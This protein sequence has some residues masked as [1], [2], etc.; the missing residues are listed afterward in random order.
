MHPYISR[1][2]ATILSYIP[3]SYLH[4][5]L[6]TALPDSTQDFAPLGN[7]CEFLNALHIRSTAATRSRSAPPPKLMG[8]ITRPGAVG[9]G[10]GVESEES[11]VCGRSGEEEVVEEGGAGGGD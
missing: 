7:V 10:G 11:E 8:S 3:T 5:W 9:S 4:S 6:E 2:L 1:L